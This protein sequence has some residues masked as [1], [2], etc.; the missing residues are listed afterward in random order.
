LLDLEVED[1][2]ASFCREDIKKDDDNKEWFSDDN[3]LKVMNYLQNY[4]KETI[5]K[6]CRK[7]YKVSKSFA[8]KLE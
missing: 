7:K 6:E 8:D 2:D 4:T 1:T 5:V 3:L